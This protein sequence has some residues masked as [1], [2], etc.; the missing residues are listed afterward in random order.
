MGYVYAYGFVGNCVVFADVLVIG[1][2]GGWCAAAVYK[3]G[4]LRARVTILPVA[5]WEH[6]CTT[7]SIAQYTM[8]CN[9][10]S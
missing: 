2:V 6:V 5:S 9:A 7:V 8:R 10:E 1:F 4:K 3:T